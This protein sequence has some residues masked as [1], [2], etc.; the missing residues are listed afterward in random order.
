MAYTPIL[1]EKLIKTGI[2]LLNGFDGRLNDSSPIEAQKMTLIKLLQ[3]A[4]Q[5]AFGA[6]YDFK[7]ILAS[8]DIAK[9]FQQNVPCF[10]YN[11]L[12][13]QWWHR[14]LRGEPDI[15]WKGAVQYFAL[16]SGTTG[17][18]SKYIPITADMTKSMRH[19]AL[20]MFTALPK[21]NLPPGLFLKHWLMVG[22]S[23][24][25]NNMGHC[26]TGDLSGINARKP[27]IWVQPYFKPGPKI[28]ALTNWDDRLK[29]IAR[30][31]HK[32]DVGILTGI[33]SWIQLTLEYVIEYHGLK[34]IHE[35]WPNLSIF[36]TGGT[37]FEPY[38]K[39]FEKLLARPLIYQDSYLA[40]EGFIAYQSGPGRKGM[41][42]LLNNQIFYEFVPFNEENFDEDGNIKPSAKALTIADVEEG[43]DYAIL[44]ST[45]AGAWRYL[46]GDTVRFTDKEASEIIITGRTKHFLSIC[47]EHLSVDNMNAAVKKMCDEYQMGIGEFIVTG[48]QSG[49]HFAH[50]WYIGSDTT[51]APEKIALLL[52]ENL[53]AINDDYKAERGAMLGMPKVKILPNELFIDWQRSM[54]KMN[55][56]SKI[57][58]VIKNEK[59]VEWEKFINQKV[60]V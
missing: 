34:N 53:K 5:T 55:G 31:A 48:T 2:Q 58:R 54:G 23:S 51:I 16:S 37:A 39:S 40:S 42:L 6:H 38:R 28:A 14:T 13:E 10:D 45:C 49:S 17:A 32:W 19:G 50:Q 35:I 22:G 52:D 36:V 43:V 7:G 44:L 56:Q 26:Y 60:S 4:E 20:R 11:S 8:G 41:K 25:L 33:P 24:S 9:A 27:P 12:F 21:Y 15:C 59:L 57:P 18:S 47:G 1:K 46:I 29:A 3:K 30:N